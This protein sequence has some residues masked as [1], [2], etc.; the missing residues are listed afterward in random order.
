MTEEERRKLLAPYEALGYNFG[1]LGSQAETTGPAAP[2]SSSS[3]SALLA[4]PA[5]A[6]PP[7][8]TPLNFSDYPGE[9]IKG[10]ISG[11]TGEL[12][13][14]ALYLAGKDPV[15]PNPSNPIPYRLG[16]LAGMLNPYSLPTRLTLGAESLVASRLLPKA[17]PLAKAI[18]AGAIGN[19]PLGA[20]SALGQGENP[21]EGAISAGG[22]GA[23]IG[24][25]IQKVAPGVNRY[26]GRRILPEFPGAVDTV[27][28]AAAATA[29]PTGPF[30]GNITPTTVAG[31]KA[32]QAQEAAVVARQQAEPLR[33]ILGPEY[34]IPAPSKDLATQFAELE[35]QYRV[36]GDLFRGEAA[37]A[38]ATPSLPYTGAARDFITQQFDALPKES[39]GVQLNWSD[40]ATY[41]NKYANWLLTAEKK[42][43]KAPE[44]P[45]D[46]KPKNAAEIQGKKFVD[47]WIDEFNQEWQR[48]RQTAVTPEAT[49]TATTKAA[50]GP[51]PADLT[52]P[53]APATPP[54]ATEAATAAAPEA[55]P[56]AATS[57]DLLNQARAIVQAEGPSAAL[58]QRRLKI[59][60]GRAVNILN[61]LEKERIA[62]LPT[63]SEAGLT[64]PTAAPTPISQSVEE[65]LA[66]IRG[67]LGYGRSPIAAR[68][69]TP[70]MVEPT[71]SGPTIRV[72]PEGEAIPAD[73]NLLPVP[74]TP[75]V[76]N[77][78]SPYRRLAPELE[79]ERVRYGQSRLRP[80]RLT[81]QAPEYVQAEAL[82][83]EL[84]AWARRAT[85]ER[86]PLPPALE[87]PLAAVE[88]ASPFAIPEAPPQVQTLT[89]EIVRSDLPAPI[90][91]PEDAAALV[92]ENARTSDRPFLI[93]QY[94]ATWVR[95]GVPY[96][97][98]DRRLAK[99]A[100]GIRAEEFLVAD[101]TKSGPPASSALP[102]P[103][104]QL[105]PP[106]SPLT[107]EAL[108]GLSLE[109]IQTE[110]AR[111]KIDPATLIDEPMVTPEAA[112][113]P[114]TVPAAPFAKPS[115]E[116]Q[117]IKKAMGSVRRLT[118]TK[119]LAKVTPDRLKARLTLEKEE[120]ITTDRLSER[121][122]EL[123]QYPLERIPGDW[124]QEIEPLL[125][126]WEEAALGFNPKDAQTIVAQNTVQ[127]I[128]KAGRNAGKSDRA[129]AAEILAKMRTQ[130][131]TE[132]TG[133]AEFAEKGLIQSGQYAGMA[134]V[135]RPKTREG[136]EKIGPEF[137]VEGA[138]V[139]QQLLGTDKANRLLSKLY[140]RYANL[141]R[142]AEQVI[143]SIDDEAY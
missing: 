51:E 12:S 88:E 21:I 99:I 6:P 120:G 78:P 64:S 135:Q 33:S 73:T 18:A 105:S 57:P 72:T 69:A 66:Q 133:K 76:R 129:I 96:Q 103:I 30:P 13:D 117:A 97:E 17:A 93:H 40:E 67:E 119:N 46:L 116:G 91:L 123:R 142:G 47:E 121:L 20:L 89:P 34:N 90:T 74:V 92:L 41:G 44:L 107:R 113:L 68:R 3:L 53:A 48:R 23:G 9:V 11:G 131:A 138:R 42:G 71:P 31:L 45:Q 8:A 32:K 127:G 102:T 82:S 1:S 50:T 83:S 134:E 28:D 85:R 132:R 58:L 100:P 26:L 137:L 115:P 140:P 22:Y 37:P 136:G 62:A 104:R 87:T 16:Y 56:I 109:E 55:T 118:A 63:A 86:P 10:L 114:A 77:L 98:I 24:G 139:L 80:Q 54:A 61:Q 110:L 25:L 141:P 65:Q 79:Q 106:P 5:A 70:G 111:R 52:A 94:I 2:G 130:V 122:A 112:T 81:D 75:L 4:A 128:V 108:S 19:A 101:P 35:E 15:N 29:A 59:G 143:S 124:R 36:A 126:A 7:A 60:Y 39:G 125:A 27:A 14:A 38:A 84:P 95:E 49:A 43:K